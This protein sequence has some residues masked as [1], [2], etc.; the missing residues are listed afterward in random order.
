MNLEIILVRTVLVLTAALS[1]GISLWGGYYLLTGLMSWRRPMDYGRHPAGTRFAVLIA[2]RNEELVIG[3]LINSLLE[4]EYPAE[5]YDIYV[6]PNNCTDNTALA[7]RQFGAEVLECTVPVRSKGEVLRFAEEQLS[8]RRYDAFCVFDADNIADEQFLARMNDAFCA[9]AQ[10]CKGAMRAKNP[11]D[12]WLSGCYGLYFTLFDTF[13]SRARMSCGLS[14]KLVGTGFAVHR[15]VLE[16]FGGWNTSTIAED[17]EFAAQCAA[18]GVRVCFV[19]GAL[20]Y[21]EAPN[22]FAV[23]LRQRRRWCSG[24]MD[25]AVRMDAPLV[26]AL[27]GSAPLRALDALLIVNA[28]FL[29]A[30][31][32]LPLTLTILSSLVQGTAGTLA[33]TGAV[34]LTLS[35]LGLMALAAL[36]AYLGGYRDRRVVRTVAGFP[37][38]MAAWLPLQLVSLVSRTRSWQPI[39]HTR[40]V[41]AENLH[42][43]GFLTTI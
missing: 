8:G 6:I 42:D 34:S 25:V 20:T 21:D 2:A 9:G 7:A 40:A 32:L 15:A 3:P 10:V 23:S 37:L 5:L 27:R 1:V 41:R 16:R 4:Q 12:S 39:A 18:N 24:I 17:A 43:A 22:D 13:F 38:F 26:S 29:Q 11:Y 33:L 30:L 28:P 19:P 31:T 14:S 36:L 35:T